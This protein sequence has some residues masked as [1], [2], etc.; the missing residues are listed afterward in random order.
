MG[1]SDP[2]LND[3]GGF[4]QKSK[5]SPRGKS[6]TKIEA[7]FVLARQ[8]EASDLYL[9]PGEN[10][11]LKIHGKLERLKEYPVLAGSRIEELFYAAIT[12]AQRQDFESRMELEL[13]YTTEA[14]GTIQ[15]ILYA[16]ESGIG[17]ACRLVPFEIP[18][19]GDM[20]PME[21]LERIPSFDRGLILITGKANCGKAITIA[22]IIDH[23]NTNSNKSIVTIED[24]IRF[25]HKS[26]SS[27]I[28]QREVG[29]HVKNYVGGLQT[30]MRSDMDVIYFT[31]IDSPETLIM[32]MTAAESHLVLTTS[33]SFGSVAWAIRKLFDYFPTDRQEY[34][35]TH[36]S[37]VLRALIWQHIIPV[38]GHT[39]TKVAMEIMFSNE[40]IAALIQNGKLHK[41]H[42]EIQKGS[43]GMQTMHSSLSRMGEIAVDIWKLMAA[44]VGT[45]LLLAL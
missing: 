6:G 15:I 8:K 21:S 18:P 41:V 20:G 1:V 30:S 11:V 17:A 42:G 38:E 23:I 22:S 9:A 24:P 32:A 10:P 3:K 25:A 40:K 19:L 43:E 12:P 2:P 44:D 7:L 37:R 4:M 28:F 34:V 16:S 26:K 33:I 35:R 31:E 39:D 27:L 45:T 13:T 5:H 36:L 29:L 14:A